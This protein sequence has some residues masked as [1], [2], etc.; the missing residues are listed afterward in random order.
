MKK[1]IKKNS[2]LI[3]F[4]V[5]CII[6]IIIFYYLRIE[7]TFFKAKEDIKNSIV[8]NKEFGEIYKVKYNNYFIWETKEHGYECVP[9][10]IYTKDKKYNI[11]VILNEENYLEKPIG[12]VVNNQIYMEE[13]N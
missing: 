1:L 11:C 4:V 8:L 5:I 7:Q 9:M 2:P 10:K 13:G 3:I 6:L 12:Y